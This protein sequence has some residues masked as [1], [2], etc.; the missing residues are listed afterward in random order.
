MK[1][2]IIYLSLFLFAA[3]AQAT[4]ITA[5]D[6]IDICKAD[7]KAV[8]IDC[9]RA[10]NYTASHVKGAVNIFPQ[11]LF[12]GKPDG[13]FKSAD[14][15]AVF[16]GSKGISEA[17]QIILYDDGSNKYTSTIHF[18]LDYLGAEDVKILT[19]NM[20]EWEK[21]RIPLT[22]AAT[23]IAPATFNA[24]P[25]SGYMIS[26][27]DFKA[28]TDQSSYTLIDNR[29]VEEFQ[30]VDVDKKSKGHLPN[31]IG[32]FYKDFLNADGSYKTKE[33]IDAIAKKYAVAPEKEVILYC[34]SNI[35]AA[36]GYYAFKVLLNYPDVK[37]LE[38][39]YNYWV[40]DASN[41]LTK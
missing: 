23:K 28:K 35:L 18:V 16:F 10:A 24:K 12:T 29:K 4:L 38:G 30:G 20:A 19:K 2:I 32:I 13:I 22:S 39:G 41:P 26:I 7:P 37:I 6:F 15:L 33:E 25:K 14:E 21:V 40:L 9:D 5:K 34:N 31:A 36:V 17:S 8:I 11:E 27:A 3:Q 1:R